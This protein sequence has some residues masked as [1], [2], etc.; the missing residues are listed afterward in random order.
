[1]TFNNFNSNINLPEVCRMFG[2][3]G[4]SYVK[5]PKFGWFAYNENLSQVLHLFQLFPDKDIPNLYRYLTLENRSAQEFAIVYSE[6]SKDQL[7]ADYTRLRYWQSLFRDAQE[8]GICSKVMFHRGKGGKLR[9][10]DVLA[11]NNIAKLAETKMGWV[12]EKI[13]TEYTKAEWPEDARGKLLLPTYCT[14]LHI[15]SLHVF[16]HQLEKERS[17][18]TNDEQGWFGD[19]NN[20]VVSNVKELGNNHGFTWDSKADFWTRTPVELSSNLAVS[21]CIKIWAEAKNTMFQTSPLQIIKSN[22]KSKEV[23]LY[24]KILTRK[25]IKKAEA[26]LNIKLLD[27]WELQQVQEIDLNQNIKVVNKGNQYW[28]E[29]K[30][31]GFNSQLT[32]FALQISSVTRIKTDYFRK[33]VLKYQDKEIDV[34]LKEEDFSTSKKLV[35][36]IHT[37]F[38]AHGLG[39]PYIFSDYENYLKDIVTKF[40]INAPVVND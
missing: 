14:P 37:V 2:I 8:E 38:L 18:W 30:K 32:N 3:K 10:K 34:I 6:A 20:L 29:H 22:R 40:N 17:I 4:L 19:L 7:Y 16:D 1:M 39:I 21:E 5:L 26:E 33:C 31:K 27:D 24:H 35:E 12:T 9:M 28:F 23:K 36:A 13:L 11:N 15:C 25:Q